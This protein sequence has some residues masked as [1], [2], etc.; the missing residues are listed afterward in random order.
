M[1]MS[2][3][4]ISNPKSTSQK[5]VLERFLTYWRTS[6]IRPYIQGKRVLD[7]GCGE[8]LRTLRA[9]QP[10][11]LQGI[12]YDILFQ[13]LPPQ[14]IDAFK[15]FG[16]LDQIE[17]EI[18]CVTSLA[19][20]EHIEPEFLPEILRNLFKVTSKQG[21]IIGTVPRPPA[22]PVLEFLSY[23]LGL[24]DKTQI[25][26]HKIYYDKSSLKKQIQ[27]TGWKMTHYSTF[28]FGMNSFFVLEKGDL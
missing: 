17:E 28:Q 1:Y 19:C 7:F 27:N 10:L 20:F 14:E 15:I 5:A 23:K 26:D 16:S 25:L 24:I 3:L 13:G 6:K 2:E 11:I 18:D 8:H 12:G 22:K 9:I 4:V 21:K